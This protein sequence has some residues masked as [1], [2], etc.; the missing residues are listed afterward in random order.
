MRLTSKTRIDGAAV[1]RG[2]A[3]VRIGLV[4]LGNMGT[5]HWMN[6]QQIE[7]C[8]VTAAVGSAA[9]SR[10]KAG[11]WGVPLYASLPE[12]LSEAELDA[13]D[14]CTP[15]FLHPE[16]IRTSLL[17]GKSVITEKPLALHRCEAESLYD[18]A[19][20]LGLHLFVAQ[21]TRF[22]NGTQALRE[23]VTSGRCGAVHDAFFRRLS[24]VPKWSAGNWM[25]DRRQS[26]TLAFD[27]HIHDLDTIVSLFGAPQRLGFDTVTGGFSGTEEQYRFLYRYPG[28]EVCAEAAWFRARFP[29][30]EDWRVCFEKGVAVGSDGGATLYS[31]SGEPLSLCPEKAGDGSA[32]NMY[33][34]ELRHFVDCIARNSDSELITREQITCVI[35]L[36]EDIVFSAESGK[37]TACT[38]L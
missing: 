27:L 9:R 13:V 15:T 28:F 25:L 19:E 23:L 16:Q 35:A 10:E 2:K 20:Q 3:M 5:T 7:G 18:L 17:A 29:F 24:G 14:I 11:E 32:A 6:Y 21:V 33:E 8:R 36:L 34:A 37:E 26:G 22:G 4:G 31:D 30:T 1:L 12:M 38:F